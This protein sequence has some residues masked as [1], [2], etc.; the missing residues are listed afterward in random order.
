[1]LGK[2]KSW[3]IININVTTQLNVQQQSKKAMLEETAKELMYISPVYLHPE[4]WGHSGPVFS[5]K[6]QLNWRMFQE[7][8]QGL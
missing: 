3:D 1:M 6:R 8:L 7:S 2:L 5:E 4:F